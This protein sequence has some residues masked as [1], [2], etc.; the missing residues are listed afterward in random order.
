MASD[1]EDKG[2]TRDLPV[3]QVVAR[4]FVRFRQELGLGQAEAAVLA[5]VT[6]A[7]LLR[8][9]RGLRNYPRATTLQTFAALYSRKVEHFFMQEPPAADEEAFLNCPVW[10]VCAAPGLRPDADLEERLQALLSELT[11]EQRGRMR[12]RP[13]KGSDPAP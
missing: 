9:E 4:N 6:P 5:G 2:L 11:R 10:T 13:K 3:D 1:D 7:A 12:A 8:I